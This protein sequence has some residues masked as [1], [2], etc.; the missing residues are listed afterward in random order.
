MNPPLAPVFKRIE[1]IDGELSQIYKK[2]VI[3][4]IRGDEGL[5]QDYAMNYWRTHR[6]AMEKIGREVSDDVGPG[7]C[8]DGS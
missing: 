2:S 3:A 4:G 8:D 6:A 1:D 5:A 7:G